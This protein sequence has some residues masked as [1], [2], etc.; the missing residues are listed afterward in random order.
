MNSIIIAIDGYSSCGKS[1]LARDMANALNFIYVDSGA[2]YRAVTHY[3]LEKDIS[4]DNESAIGNALQQMNIEFKMSDTGVQEIFSDG[5]SL[6]KEI[7]SMEVSQSVSEVAALPQVRK[8]L[9]K[10][11]QKLGVNGGIVM[12]GRDIG[13]VV[14]PNAVL[15]LFVTADID[16]RTER[17]FTELVE[18]GI[19]I[20]RGEVRANLEKRDFIDSTR[21]DSPLVQCPDAI[22]LDN[23]TL[24]RAGQL[25]LALDWFRKKMSAE[26]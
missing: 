4:L 18:R 9:V 26:P 10:Q 1:T 15:K 16:I 19:D 17:R 20:N 5:I 6:E 8:F 2:M 23:T 3:F 12:D 21:E 22:V 7:R 13:S 14:F 11:Q 24:D 25:N